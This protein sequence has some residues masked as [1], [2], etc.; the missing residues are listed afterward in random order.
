MKNQVRNALLGL[1]VGDALG[2]PAEFKSREKLK[3]KP[4]TDMTGYGTHDQPPG[5]WS[6]D[7]SL[8]LCLA[9]ELIAGYDLTRIGQSFVDWL[10][11]QRWTPH[12]TVFDVG[13]TTRQAIARLKNGVAPDLA[14]D[15]EET[16]NGNGAL[17]RI[18]PLLFYIKDFTAA[19][20]Y[21]ITR[22]VACLTHGHVRSSLACFYYLELAGAIDEGADKLVAYRKAN[23]ALQQI[24]LLLNINPHE[25]ALCDRLLTG[26]I[27]ELKEA[28]IQSTGYVMHTLEASVWCLLTTDDYE[29]AVLQAVNLGDDT[30]TTGAVTGGLAGLLYGA[31]TIPEDWLKAIARLDEIEAVSSQLSVKYQQ[32]PV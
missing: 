16:S 7:S 19:K 25:A 10:Y 11:H 4:V 17:M 31:D 27:Q 13:N 32:F 29:A 20:R 15:W 9:E 6:D 1:V 28:A 3:H 12:G 23:Q 21:Q 2:V 14:G 30:D 22:E 5:T 26:K 24:I 18:L 8:T